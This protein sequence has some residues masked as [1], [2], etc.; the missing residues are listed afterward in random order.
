MEKVEGTE[1]SVSF[2]AYEANQCKFTPNFETMM[3][4]LPDLY[5]SIL[6]VHS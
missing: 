5:L 2:E 1:I 4:Y 3:P 6:V